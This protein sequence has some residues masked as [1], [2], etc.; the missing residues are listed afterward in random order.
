MRSPPPLRLSRHPPADRHCTGRIRIRLL[1]A[2][3]AG[4]LG[5]SCA[6]GPEP[7]AVEQQLQTGWENVQQKDY[8]AAEQLASELIAR[9]SAGPLKA[10]AY[11]LRAAARLGAG[12]VPAG[13]ADLLA[14]LGTSDDPGVRARSLERLGDLADTQ[15][16]S[17][18]V[19]R[20]YSEALA[21]DETIASPGL[22]YRLGLHQQ[23]IGDQPAQSG[24]F[25]PADHWALAR[26]TYS[27][28]IE[29]YPKAAEA[30]LAAIAAR[31]E[32]F[33]I[34]LARSSDPADARQLAQ[35]AARSPIIRQ[36]G[37]STRV[38]PVFVRSRAPLFGVFAGKFPNAQTAEAALDAVVAEWP[39]AV[40][41]P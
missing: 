6:C 23:R 15:Q 10:R 17:T 16:L 26:L 20:Y 8:P 2:V 34:E 12:D 32:H 40:L 22:L 38:E 7:A 35:A 3:I 18:L 37:L 28:L 14:S 11:Q 19:V 21:A 36:L 27:R 29:Q 24:E 39:A 31:W 25:G 1:P 4:C 9:L 33:A 30:E 5:L 13:R 41:R